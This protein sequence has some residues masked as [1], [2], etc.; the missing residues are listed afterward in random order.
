MLIVYDGATLTCGVRRGTSFPSRRGKG[1]RKARPVPTT[2]MPRPNSAV[3]QRAGRNL[4]RR[5][6]R[7]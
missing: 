7:A 6:Y 5:C 2:P 4:T 3:V 1:R